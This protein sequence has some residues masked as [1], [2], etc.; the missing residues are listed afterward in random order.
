M[1]FCIAAK[2]NEI[3]VSLFLWE[4]IQNMLREIVVKQ[5]I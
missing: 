4:L 5:Y 2:K 3:S 1:E